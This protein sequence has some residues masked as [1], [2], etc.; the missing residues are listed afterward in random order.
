MT[1]AMVE[2]VPELLERVVIGGDLSKLQ[3]TERLQYYREVCASVGLN[4]LTKPFEYL[5]LNG[6]LI[7]Y[8]R[9]DATDQL[10]KLHKVSVTITAREQHGDVYAVVARA[11]DGDGRT[12]ESVGAVTTQGLRGDA[13]ANA[14][15]KAETKAKRRVTLS[16][17][18]LGLMDE[19]EVETVPG[20]RIVPGGESIPVLPTLAET[21][22]ETEPESGRQE[23]P[24]SGPATDA[25]PADDWIVSFQQAAT[26]KALQHL[27]KGCTNLDTWGSF[28]KGE[29]DS[30]THH[31]NAAKV[32]LGG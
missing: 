18:G 21:A 9:R 15:M 14:L 3:P 22:A 24:T 4:P 32:R 27:W 26:L 8:A 25:A 2:T 11:T 5:H 13:L 19:T 1:T 20:A 23:V 17:C 29:Q 7:L 30:L 10:R 6:K 28:T 31:K 16:I 12:D